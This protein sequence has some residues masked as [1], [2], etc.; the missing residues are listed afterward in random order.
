MAIHSL[1]VSF[2]IDTDILLDVHE[3]FPW[4]FLD[5]PYIYSLLDFADSLL[6][7]TNG[8]LDV[9]DSI[10]Y[11]PIVF[12]DV[13]DSLPDIWTF[14]LM[15]YAVGSISLARFFPSLRSLFMAPMVEKTLNL[16]KIY[17]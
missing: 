6:N 5:V 3:C 8:L 17:T 12:F 1:L 7:P 9:S 10:L 15:S 4:E 13:L 2:L 14:Q 16:P 11:V